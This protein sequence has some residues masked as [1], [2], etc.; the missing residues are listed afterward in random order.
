MWPLWICSIVV[1]YCL[2]FPFRLA[3][4]WVSSCFALTVLIPLAWLQGGGSRENPLLEVLLHLYLKGILLSLGLRVCYSGRK[5][6]PREPHIFVANHTSVTDLAVVSGIGRV[7]AV[8][9]QAHGGM[10]GW[11]CRVVLKPLTDSLLFDRN[12]SR[13]RAIVSLKMREHVHDPRNKH[14][15]LIFPE[16]TCVN[17]SSTVLF[18]KGAFELDCLVCPVAIK[19]DKTHGDPYFNTREQSFM[20]H[21]FY[22]MTRWR[23]CV[24]VF[25]IPPQRRNANESSVQFS[26][27]VKAL[28]SDAAGLTNLSW[29]GYLKN[30]R[31]SPEKRDKMRLETRR[32]YVS[33]LSA[34][35]NTLKEAEPD[36]QQPILPEKDYLPDWLSDDDRT[37][38]QNELLQF[39]DDEEGN[40]SGSNFEVKLNR[41]RESLISK[42]NQLKE[43]LKPDQKSNE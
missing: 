33:E 15:L 7:H 18:H 25:W 24:N 34:K 29:D 23:S 32:E 26:D 1:R 21:L 37:T 42:F 19:Y 16:G 6:N 8:V 43:T 3:V 41:S 17:N 12:E 38:V 14:P 35:L 9:A 10:F 20:Q 27:R 31:P 11:M 39:T 13:D 40:C 4:F 36:V 2:L 22:V 28:I 30:Y 5:P